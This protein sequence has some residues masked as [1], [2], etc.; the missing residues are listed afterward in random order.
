MKQI[1]LVLFFTQI[2]Y[3][4]NI[5]QLLKDGSKAYANKN[6][7]LAKKIFAKATEDYPNNKDLWYNLAATELN[8]GEKESACDHFYKLYLLDDNTIEKEIN[9]FC[10]NFKNGLIVSIK[11]VEEKPKFIFEGKEYPLFENENLNKVYIN[12]FIKKVRKS[13]TICEKIKGKVF[14]LFSINQQGIFDGKIIKINV[15]NNDLEMIKIEMNS[16]IRNI[17]TYIPPRNKGKIVQLW[18]RWILP[19]DF[20]N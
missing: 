10:P 12:A 18:E 15:D 8:L 16:I 14:I 5:D 2:V 20:S 6:Y 4:Q 3:S 11:D 7:E 17:V 13:K 19:V 9:E 1:F